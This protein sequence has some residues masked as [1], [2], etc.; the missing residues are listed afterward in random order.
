VL[1]PTIPLGPPAAVE[2]NA[3]GVEHDTVLH[4][5]PFQAIFDALDELPTGQVI[6]LAVDHDPEP[7]LATLERRQPGRYRWE[8]LLTGPVRW[9]GLIRRAAIDDPHTSRRL[10]PRLVRR[11][12]ETRARSRLDEDLRAIALDLLGPSDPAVLPAGPAAWV[13]DAAERAIESVRDDSLTALVDRLG[14]ILAD[15]PPAVADC[16]EEATARQE[17]GIV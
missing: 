14:A 6:R 15:A 3:C 10:S 13:E 5:P 8:P 4:E 7:L 9:V 11:V 1:A 12:A 2:F 16:L 17:A